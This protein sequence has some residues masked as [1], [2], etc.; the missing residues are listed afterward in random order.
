MQTTTYYVRTDDGEHST[1]VS[2]HDNIFDALVDYYDEINDEYQDDDIEEIE[3]G[4]YLIED[5][6]YISMDTLQYH[7]IDKE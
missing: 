1:E 4:Y 2:E 6:Q 3:L 5:N 7:S